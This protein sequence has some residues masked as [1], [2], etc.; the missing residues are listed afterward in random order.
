LAL[1][2]VYNIF[3]LDA[4]VTF[5][6][7]MWFIRKNSFSVFAYITFDTYKVTQNFFMCACVTFSTQRLLFSKTY[8]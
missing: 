7:P 4:C 5:W 8:K 1:K 3:F 2:V 6:H